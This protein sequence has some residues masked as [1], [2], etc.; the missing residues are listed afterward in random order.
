MAAGETPPKKAKVDDNDEAQAMTVDET[1]KLRA[2]LG[3]AP[4]EVTSEKP[5]DDGQI[6]GNDGTR[7]H[8]KPAENITEKKKSNKIRDKVEKRR[9]KRDIES[10]LKN[11]KGLGESD[12]EDDI[13]SWVKRSRKKDKEKIKADKK[14]ASI[15]AHEQEMDEERSFLAQERRA[16]LYG[17][18]ALAGLTVEHDLDKFGEGRD[19]ILTLKDSKIMDE[20]AGKSED[21][22]VNV[23]M[24]DE[25]RAA[26]YVTD[27][28]SSK[29]VDKSGYNPMEKYDDDTMEMAAMGMGE[30]KLLA[31]YNDTI[32]GKKIKKF[33]I[34]KDGA[35]STVAMEMRKQ[36]REELAARTINL[37]DISIKLAQD[38]QTNDEA[39][40]FK[41]RKK[42]RKKVRAKGVQLM[43]DTLERRDFEVDPFEK[44]DHGS[45]RRAAVII[46]NDDKMEVQPVKEEVAITEEELQATL[47]AAAQ[48]ISDATMEESSFKEEHEVKTE[49]AENVIEDAVKNDVA[50]NSS[51]A[52]TRRLLKAK[53]KMEWCDPAASLRARISGISEKYKNNQS[54]AM[55]GMDESELKELVLND[56]DEFCRAVGQANAEKIHEREK[57]YRTEKAFNNKNMLNEDGIDFDDEFS[58]VKKQRTAIRKINDQ[59]LDGV[60]KEPLAGRGLAAALRVAFQKGY[61]DGKLATKGTVNVDQK[62]KDRIS[63]HTYSLEDKNRVDHLDKYASD[64]YRRE[65]RMHK[66][67]LQ[68]FSEKREYRPNISVAYIDEVGRAKTQKEAFRDLSHK[69]HGK[70]SGK[71]KQEKRAKRLDEDQ[72]MLKM[73]STDTP[74]NTVEMM[75]RKQQQ[76]NSAFISLTGGSM[77]SSD[78]RK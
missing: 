74:L 51:L 65:S 78:T 37:N 73:S 17:G 21:V 71:M 54:E 24:M 23:N 27:V 59:E 60:E 35:I 13:K 6:L 3:L 22:L 68:A 25:E 20:E 1:N 14:E 67:A 55:D 2:K 63:A 16:K 12:G 36:M 53:A 46:S 43:D 28:K 26:Q 75:R 52:R 29:K 30:E 70:T 57:E 72:A 61:V 45:R 9:K 58:D 48:N 15:R 11:V 44:N 31:K 32:D 38:Y 64:K 39:N 50:I 5:N 47:K 33:A 49:P 34:G 19:V 77:L 4:L 62:H 69:F 18:N 8:H 40:Q 10:K 76:T 7:F 41:K 56:V 66:G 42:K